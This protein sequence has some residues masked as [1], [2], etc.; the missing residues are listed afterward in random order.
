M[1]KKQHRQQPFKTRM[2]RKRV[3][4]VLSKSEQHLKKQNKEFILHSTEY[5]ALNEELELTKKMAEESDRLKSAFL[6]N[7][8]HE[9]RTPMNA[10]IGFSD[11]LMR[12]DLP[13]VKTEQ[14]LQIINTGCKRLLSVISDIVDIS[15]IEANQIAVY[16]ELVNINLLLT[17][18]YTSYKK[19]AC[20]NKI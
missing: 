7:I 5:L 8:F 14:F 19:Q 10:I 16:K 18:I 9:I 1:I 13:K 4:S 15:K 6:A 20:N 2:H 17:D 11:Y 3:A 12:A